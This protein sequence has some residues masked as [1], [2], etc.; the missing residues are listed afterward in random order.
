VSL[1]GSSRGLKNLGK[2]VDGVLVEDELIPEAVW[3]CLDVAA[4]CPSD[5]V[6]ERGGGGN[7]VGMRVS[8]AARGR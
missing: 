1:I 6:V 2:A 3:A 8:Q 4:R 7:V 5:E